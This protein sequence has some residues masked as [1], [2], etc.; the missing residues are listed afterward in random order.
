MKITYL[1]PTAQMGGAEVSLLDMLASLRQAQPAWK[2]QL[3]AAG[4]G[5]LVEQAA[6]LG[7]EALVVPFPKSF[8]QLGDA[9]ASRLAGGR[10]TSRLKLPGKLIAA[11]VSVWRY[12]RQLRHAL[13]GSAPDII[14]TNGFK[15]HILGMWS[16][17]HVPI[18]WHIHDYI[19]PRPVMRRLLRHYA[20][21]CA[22]IIA[23]SNSV[24]ADVKSAC[25]RAKEIHTVYNAVDLDK[26]SPAGG[27]LDLDELAGLPPA[28][29]GT[30]RV[31]LVATFAR[32]KGHETFLRALAMLPSDLSVRGYVV[33]GGLY[34]THGSQY[35]LAELKQLAAALKITN[36]VGFTGFTDQPAAAMRSLDILVHASTEPEPFGLVIAEGMACGRAVVVSNIGGANEIINCGADALCHTAGDAMQLAECLNRLATDSHLR[37]KVGVEARATAERRFHRMRLAKQLPPIYINAV[38]GN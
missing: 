31:G 4:H 10:R 9:G 24:A 16:R 11:T 38:Q 15:M 8:A 23:N 32:W 22:V 5:A 7:V 25:P 21:K 3:I 37:S 17:P 29:K 34:Q 19:S 28:P 1:S 20:H 26:F 36:R 30:I 2:L 12:R 14:H 35:T 6:A 33:G 13:E 18:I 27:T